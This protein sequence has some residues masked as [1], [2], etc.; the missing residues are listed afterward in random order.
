MS[1]F[2]KPGTNY[3][4]YNQNVKDALLSDKEESSNQGDSGVTAHFNFSRAP[5]SQQRLNLPISKHRRQILYAME[6]FKVIVIV[7]E[8][9]SGK[10]TQIPQYLMEGGWSN[11][12]KHSILCTQP[13]RLAAISL[14]NRVAVETNTVHGTTV[15]HNVRFLSKFDPDNTHILFATDG[16]LVRTAL[17]DP[18]L[19]Q[20]SVIMVDEA[21][22][23]GMN[24]DLVLGILKKVRRKRKEL[25]IVICSAT[26]DAP[27]FLDYFCDKHKE[28]GVIIS[29]DGRQYPVDVMYKQ[30]PSSDY[31]KDTVK[32][33]LQIH[34]QNDYETGDILCFLPS[35][36]DIDR[37]IRY[38]GED[39]ESR[40]S[41]GTKQSRP[42]LLPLY[43]TLPYNLQTRVFQTPHQRRS[44]TRRII[45]A[46]NIAETSVTVPNIRHVVDSGFVKLPFFDPTNGFERLITCPISRASAKQRAGRAGNGYETVILFFCI[47]H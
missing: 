9:G 43:G 26:I 7:G 23:R 28:D 12:P 32:A 27:A 34:F 25:R 42:D 11:P 46:T 41:N 20:Y 13:R 17:T 18:F 35:G 5:I 10:S 36:E 30:I 38:A 15:G 3:N 6:E 31:I 16:M 45:F 44:N 40:M 22:E 24:S 8:T 29:I 33:S 4:S 2:W 37:A 21:H 47:S 14:S 39:I 1:A 19:R